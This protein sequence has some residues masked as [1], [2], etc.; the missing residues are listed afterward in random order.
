[1][2]GNPKFAQQIEP[3]LLDLFEELVRALPRFRHYERELYMTEA[4]EKALLAAYMETITVFAHSIAFFRNNPNSARRGVHWSNFSNGISEVIS[5]LRRCSTL[6]D[7]TAD[8]TIRISRE[9]RTAE[10]PDVIKPLQDRREKEIN[11][12]CYMIPYGLNLRFYGRSVETQVLREGLDPQ[13]KPEGLKAMAIHGLGGV[14]KTQ[15]ALHYAN[16][17]L[18]L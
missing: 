1:M 4:F 14:G 5:N 15:L 17:S 11:L 6:V 16:T 7:K 8:T 12:P 2:I 9:A 3:Q 13:R 18:R 10:T